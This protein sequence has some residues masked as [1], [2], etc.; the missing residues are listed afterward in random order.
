MKKGNVIAEDCVL[1]LMSVTEFISEFII[2]NYVINKI[3]AN[4]SNG[5]ECL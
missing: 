5:N 2:Q 4:F 1:C 3:F